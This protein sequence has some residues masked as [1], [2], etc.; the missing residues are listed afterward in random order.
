MA[1]Q[2]ITRSAVQ[3]PLEK[4]P[5]GRPIRRWEDNI[6]MDV[7]EIRYVVWKVDGTCQENVQWRSVVLAV[8]NLEFYYQKVC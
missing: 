8:L 5:H 2:I 3:E 6:K 7:R 1:R 4:W